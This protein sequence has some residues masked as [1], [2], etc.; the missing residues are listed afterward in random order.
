MLRYR[1]ADNA[2]EFDSECMPGYTMINPGAEPNG[3]L[4]ACPDE[5]PSPCINNYFLVD[6]VEATLSQAVEA[7][8]KVM[9]PKKPIPG[10]GAFAF[11][12]DPE[13]IAVGLFQ[14]EKRT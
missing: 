3:G 9:M 1:F 14:E 4:L 7:G 12:T 13:G 11:F 5:M 10:V 6:D 8:G 2:W